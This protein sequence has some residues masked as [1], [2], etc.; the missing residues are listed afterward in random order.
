MSSRNDRKRRSHRNYGAR[1]WESWL[2]TQQCNDDRDNV[3]RLWNNEII[4]WL[5][6]LDSPEKFHFQV[7]FVLVTLLSPPKLMLW[8][9][10]VFW[11]QLSFQSISVLSLDIF[12]VFSF[13]SFC[14]D[15]GLVFIPIMY[16]RLRPAQLSGMNIIY[17]NNF[18][19]LLFICVHFCIMYIIKL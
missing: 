15:Y 14:D 19:I 3:S 7:S 16:T 6:Q 13:I 4:S 1:N 5:W 8:I 18:Y 2:A 9:L 12:G 11:L 17:K 10:F